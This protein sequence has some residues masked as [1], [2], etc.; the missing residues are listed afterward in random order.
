MGRRDLDDRR[1]HSTAQGSTRQWPTC[2]SVSRVNPTSTNQVDTTDSRP[3][4]RMAFIGNGE[5]SAKCRVSEVRVQCT[6]ALEHY[7][8]RVRG[9]TIDGSTLLSTDYFNLFNEVIMLLGMLPDMPDMLDDVD[10]WQFKTYQQH[11]ETSGLAFAPIAIEV[12]P[13]APAETL[14]KF[15]A[16]TR[17]LHAMIEE[18]RQ[19]LRATLESGQIDSFG[20]K[21]LTFS[22]ELQQL[23]DTGSAIVHGQDG[24]LDQSAIDNLF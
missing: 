24:V 10:A 2:W 3:E 21:A 6:A 11:F 20:D 18:A 16:N 19:I 8:E 9:T 1:A 12:Y 22:M 4:V 23:V 15:E 7:R 17:K 13:H 14:E 5:R